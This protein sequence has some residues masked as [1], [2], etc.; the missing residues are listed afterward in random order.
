LA[1]DGV[2]VA[3]AYVYIKPHFPASLPPNHLHYILFNIPSIGISPETAIKLRKM[4]QLTVPKQLFLQKLI[5][6]AS[7]QLDEQLMF[8]PGL[9]VTVEAPSERWLSLIANNAGNLNVSFQ[10][11]T[12]FTI[13]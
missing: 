6:D 7:M 2:T 1:V 11:L 4:A 5:N 12:S 9:P 3:T 8:S 10:G 13:C